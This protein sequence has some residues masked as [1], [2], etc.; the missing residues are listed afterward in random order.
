MTKHCNASLGLSKY[1][2]LAPMSLLYCTSVEEFR[3]GQNG[4]GCKSNNDAHMYFFL[5][6]TCLVDAHLRWLFLNFLQT[7]NAKGHILLQFKSCKMENLKLKVTFTIHS[8]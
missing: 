2:K 6:S 5:L 4:Y 3:F 8:S 1:P 7:R